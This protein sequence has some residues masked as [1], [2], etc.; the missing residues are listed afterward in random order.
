[1][2][3]L[4]A[5]FCTTRFKV[6]KLPLRLCIHFHVELLDVTKTVFYCHE[7]F[8]DITKTVALDVYVKVPFESNLGKLIVTLCWCSSWP[9]M[10]AN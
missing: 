2:A 8:L 10:L 3:L 1:M 9:G 7:E 6:V 5:T 4:E